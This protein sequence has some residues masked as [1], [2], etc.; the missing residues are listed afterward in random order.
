MTNNDKRKLLDD[1]KVFEWL[2]VV[3]L[4]KL[5]WWEWF[6]KKRLQVF[7]DSLKLGKAAIFAYRDAEK[8]NKK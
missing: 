6:N 4:F 5:I 1:A 2:S 7:Y 8:F 3:Q